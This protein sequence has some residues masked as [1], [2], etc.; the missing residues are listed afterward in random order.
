MS[1]WLWALVAGLAL[2]FVGYAYEAVQERRYRA[3]LSTNSEILVA[4][5]RMAA[6]Y[7]PTSDGN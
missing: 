3:L 7:G 5:E 4:V 1:Y 2:L 6:K